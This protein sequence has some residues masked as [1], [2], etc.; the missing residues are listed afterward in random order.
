VLDKLIFLQVNCTISGSPLTLWLSDSRKLTDKE[1]AVAK[2]AYVDIPEGQVHYQTEGN[3]E[4]V[5]LLHQT[6]MSS[7]E[8]SLMIPI[9]AKNYKVIAIDT[10]GYGRSD[11]PPRQ[12]QVEDYARSVFSFLDALGIEKTSAVGHHTGASIAVEMAASIPERVDK[13]I[14]SGCPYYKPEA[15]KAHLTDGTAKPMEITEDGSY[16]W[17]IWEM[18]K[19]YSIRKEPKIWHKIFLNWLIAGERGEEGHF[20]VFMHRVEQRLP[21]IQSPTLI[22][23]GDMDLF[24][25]RVD[26]IKGL[27]PRNR[28]VI[29]EGGGAFVALEKPVEFAEIILDFLRNPDC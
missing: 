22:M 2:R 4:P 28:V 23:S 3:G 25:K 24:Y 6:A 11:A 26:L 8:Y 1:S 21:L 27:V 17:K 13:L 9:L 18:A 16:I 12:Y 19:T 14:L 15:G 20:A 7:D 10:L 29:L 5:L